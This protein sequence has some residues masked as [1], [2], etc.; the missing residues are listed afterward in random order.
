M[1]VIPSVVLGLMAAGLAGT[2]TEYGLHRALHARCL[3]RTRLGRSH[4]AHHH[5]NRG[6]PLLRELRDYLP[7]AAL[8]APLGL[9]GNW[10][11]CAG[12]VAGLF[13][14]AL[15]V[16]CCHNLYHYSDCRRLRCLC[17]AHR[18]HHETPTCN[19]G[20]VTGFWDAVFRTRAETPR[21][22]STDSAAGKATTLARSASESLEDLP[23][24]LKEEGAIP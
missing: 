17:A 13:G 6:Q 22:L 14:Y 1:W 12:W 18:K 23:G 2:L 19:F 21:T 24:R 7:F 3:R 9:L 20:V 8:G 10:G 5:D 15:W 16:A 4:Q 11:F